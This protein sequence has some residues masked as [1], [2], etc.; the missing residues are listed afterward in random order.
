MLAGFLMASVLLGATPITSSSIQS[1]RFEI[2]LSYGFSKPGGFAM[3]TGRSQD[4]RVLF[5]KDVFESDPT[6]V[7]ASVGYRA[8]NGWGG[9][10]SASYW[11]EDVHKCVNC[12]HQICK[13]CINFLE[14]VGPRV[15]KL[16]GLGHVELLVGAQLLYEK[17]RVERNADNFEVPVLDFLELSGLLT[18]LRAEIKAGP[19]YLKAGLFAS[20][21]VGHY[22][23]FRAPT[24]AQLRY[25]Q[26][27]VDSGFGLYGADPSRKYPLQDVSG[28]RV[29]TWNTVGL[30]LS[31]Q[32]PN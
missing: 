22:Y 8:A 32:V 21:E 19:K 7:S 14:T 17:L 4:R 12:Y 30:T 3:E 10:L 20:S 6:P 25:E 1:S 26:Y 18:G 27:L 28:S 31:I 11:E 5:Q 16:W 24:L 2:E 9:A 23:W 29:H 13:G 15:S